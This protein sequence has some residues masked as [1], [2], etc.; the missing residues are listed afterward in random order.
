MFLVSVKEFG[1][2]DD[3]ATGF[4]RQHTVY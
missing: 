2:Q 4:Y 3:A 1:V